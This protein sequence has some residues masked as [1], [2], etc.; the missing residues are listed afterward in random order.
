MCGTQIEQQIRA[1]DGKN[2]EMQKKTAETERE[3]KEAM[4]KGQC[5]PTFKEMMQ[6]TAVAATK[7]AVEKD[8]KKH[9]KYLGITENQ[10]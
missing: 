6:Q 3:N 9:Q 4:A 7:K 1:A 5:P 2:A 8:K 10:V